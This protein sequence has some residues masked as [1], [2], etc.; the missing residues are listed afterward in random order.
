[1]EFVDSYYPYVVLKRHD[2]LKNERIHWNI[3]NSIY[4]LICIT[5]SRLHFIYGSNSFSFIGHVNKIP[6]LIKMYLKILIT[7][8]EENLQIKCF[9]QNIE[10]IISL[11]ATHL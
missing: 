10:N 1:M 3:H 7:E 4:H 8:S 6:R 11:M 9:Q 2:I 5:Y